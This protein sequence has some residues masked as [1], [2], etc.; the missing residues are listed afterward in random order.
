MSGFQQHVTQS[1]SAPG[2]I[3][4]PSLTTWK[5]LRARKR[6][7]WNDRHWSQTATGDAVLSA[8]GFAVKVRNDR[9]TW[10]FSVRQVRTQSCHFGGGY[11]SNLEARLA[12]FD[13]ITDL[14]VG[15]AQPSET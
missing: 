11:R 7:R 14:L 8:D 15:R 6:E 3:S 5:K 2:T 10:T 13:L 12:A 4:D 1:M 9:G